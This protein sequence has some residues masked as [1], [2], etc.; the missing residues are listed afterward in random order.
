VKRVRLSKLRGLCSRARDGLPFENMAVLLR[1]PGTYRPHLAEAFRR[2]EIPAYFARGAREPHAAGRALLALLRCKQEGLSA[3]R[4]SEYLSLDQLPTSDVPQAWKALE[5]E[6]DRRVLSEDDDVVEAPEPSAPDGQNLRVPRIWESLL[7]DA[8]VV[9]GLPRWEERLAV[10]GGALRTR[11]GAIEDLAV[12]AHVETS[13]ARVDA[14][15]AFALP[16]LRM[17]DAL[18]SEATWGTWTDALCAIA[19][20]ALRRP[21]GVLSVLSELLPLRDVGPIP[22]HELLMALEPRLQDAPAGARSKAHGSVFIGAI[23]ESLG[24]AF[25]TVFLPGL[26]EKNFPARIFEDPLLPDAMRTKLGLSTTQDQAE[27]ERQYLRTACAAAQRELI[28]LYPRIDLETARPRTPSFYALEL[29]RATEGTL[30]GFDALSKRARESTHVRLGWPAPSDPLDAIDS[31]EHD[32]A[33]LERVLYAPS[34][35]GFARYLLEEN[36]YLGRALRARARRWSLTKW[37]PADGLVA[38]GE[39][40][41]SALLP[42]QISARSYSATALQNYALCPYR[43][44]LQAILR[45]A[46]REEP[47]AIEELDALSK[48]SMTHEI[49]YRLLLQ[50]REGNMLPLLPAKLERAFNLLERVAPEVEAEYHARLAPA[51]ERIWTD[52][53]AAIR[54]D[55]REWLRRQSLDAEFT[56]AYFE[57][58]FG[59]TENADGRDPL[60]RDEPVLLETGLRLRGSIDMV[61]VRRDGS[62]RATD[63]K[64]G[65]VRASEDNIIKGGEALQPV[66]YALALERLLPGK[67]V[68]G[69]RLAYCTHQGGFTDVDFPLDGLARDAAALVTRAVDEALSQGMFPA[70]PAP[71]ACRY[72]DYKA[73]CG[74]Y[75]ELRAKKKAKGPL[76]T[77]LTLRAHK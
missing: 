60:S 67:P 63:H 12:R 76:K 65:R 34:A 49:L 22:L 3:A 19:I 1:N 46:P 28:A 56:P 48:G 33:V 21:E 52:A 64:T 59:L 75:E 9:G 16:L 23:D 73:V 29:V 38:P 39:L 70:A 31:C 74:P 55:V 35:D 37:N 54:A 10:L 6:T 13:A 7:V 36:A 43:F 44:Y 5:G 26:A 4:F 18:P 24:L 66:L 30:I 61:E 58:A 8:S 11:A 68:L 62:L 27:A 2:A 69:G 40:G 25:D 51:I 41:K 72:C 71:D 17:L 77:L 20:A 50:L 42:H 53:M 14:L 45:L 47:E 15:V 32:L 57:L